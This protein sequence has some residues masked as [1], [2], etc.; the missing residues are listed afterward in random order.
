MKRSSPILFLRSLT[1]TRIDLNNKKYTVG[2][3]EREFLENRDIDNG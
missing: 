1:I 3:S 2:T